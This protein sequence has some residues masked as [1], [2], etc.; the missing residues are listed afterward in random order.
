MTVDESITCDDWVTSD[1]STA[2]DDWTANYAT[3]AR[4][5]WMICDASDACEGLVTRGKRAA[6]DERT[7]RDTIAVLN[8]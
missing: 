3:R 4:D 5:D 8:K 6:S 2:L 7:T 1:D